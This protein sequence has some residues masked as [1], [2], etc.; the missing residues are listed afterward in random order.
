MTSTWDRPLATLTGTAK[1]RAMQKR[2]VA[3][4]RR[5][6]GLRRAAAE[7]GVN[8]GLLSQ[9]VRGKRRAPKS[10]RAAVALGYE[11]WR[12]QHLAE[13]AEIVAWAEGRR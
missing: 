10:V 9:I 7:I 5:K 3:L 6:G 2:L 12:Q 8:P 13:I 11:E 4:I 1:P